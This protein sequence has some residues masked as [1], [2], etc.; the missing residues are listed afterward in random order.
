[1]LK[2][3]VIIKALNEERRIAKAIESA[4]VAVGPFGGEVILADS[5]STDKTVEIAQGYPIKIAQLLHTADRSCGVGAQ[6]GY[7][8][9]DG[10]YVYILDG[11][12]E[13]HADFIREAIELMDREPDVAGVGGLV[14]EKNLDSL[15]YL[16]RHQRPNPNMR[17]GKVD[18]LDMGGL[19]RRS[20]LEQIGFFTNRALHSYEEFDLAVRLRAL[21]YKL[22]RI[23]MSAVDHFGHTLPAYLLL[24]KRWKNKYLFGMGELLRCAVGTSHFWLSLRGL[25]E[26]K[27]YS[28]III[29]WL[30]LICL[31]MLAMPA[32]LCYSGVL[33]VLPWLVMFLKKRSVKQGLYAVITWNYYAAALVVGLLLPVR[34]PFQ[35][36]DSVLL[37][38]GTGAE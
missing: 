34:D 3:S 13:L 11:D 38:D 7:Q 32:G 24:K 25:N 28:V 16:A 30:L 35:P 14:V 27:L 23:N 31:P 36:V 37:F 29:W 1:M 18:R 17:P 15:E 10:E 21:G 8:Y 6:L 33:F 2:I 9:A 22:S 26:L 4:L 20:A 19:Y 5:L 12:M